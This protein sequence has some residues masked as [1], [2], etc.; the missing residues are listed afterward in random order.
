[1]KDQV[2]DSS[3]MG[4]F[5]HRVQRRLVSCLATSFAGIVHPKP[6][7][8][9]RGRTHR[10]ESVPDIH[11]YNANIRRKWSVRN[12]YS[13]RSWTH[14]SDNSHVIEDG[15]RGVSLLRVLDPNVESTGGKE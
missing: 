12:S 15:C 4:L 9:V 11:T 7:L 5:H 14:A 2:I 1:M 6:P 8:F 13:E 3:T 10:A